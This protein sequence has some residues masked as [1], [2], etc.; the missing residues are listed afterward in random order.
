MFI[1]LFILLINAIVYLTTLF[2]HVSTSDA[3]L[4]VHSEE[5]SPG[6]NGK[7]PKERNAV[8]LHCFAA[9][10]SSLQ[11]TCQRQNCFSTDFD[12]F[13]IFSQI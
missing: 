9:T 5:N 6:L 7:F 3:I 4:I 1:V 2:C 10:K 8:T 11:V 13:T 12:K